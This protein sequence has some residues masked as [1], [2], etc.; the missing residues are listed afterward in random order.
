MVNVYIKG[1][2]DEAYKAAK[3]LAIEDDQTIGTIV[4]EAIEKLAKDR[5]ERKNNLDRAL[6]FFG[7]DDK[8]LERER[9]AL[10]SVRKAI[11]EDFERKRKIHERAR[12]FGTD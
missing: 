8:A 4:S 6:G 11:T 2:K 1:V 7:K 3:K 12:H 5:L 9:K 10:R